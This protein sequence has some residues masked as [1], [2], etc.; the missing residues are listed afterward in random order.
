MV[1]VGVREWLIRPGL[2]SITSA[3][4]SNEFVCAFRCY[5]EALREV[6]EAM[7][8]HLDTLKELGRP[9]PEP[10]SCRGVGAFADVHDPGDAVQI[11]EEI[12]ASAVEGVDQALDA[13]EGACG[14]RGG[15]SRTGSKPWRTTPS[16]TAAR[17]RVSMS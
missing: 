7:E 4:S 14:S 8:L 15:S 11:V 17:C 1:D 3:F 9:I 5:E 12:D 13:S 10:V 16:S 2:T 6:L